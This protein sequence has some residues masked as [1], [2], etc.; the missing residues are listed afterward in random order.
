MY[1]S[2]QG[3]I[4]FRLIGWPV[5][6]GH[7]VEGI[8]SGMR[9]VEGTAFVA[10]PSGGMTLA[11][12]GADVIRFDPIGGSLDIGRW[13]LAR[14]GKRSLFWAGLNKGKRSIAVDFRNP[15]GQELLTRLICAAGEN[16]GI[17]STNFPARG[18]LSYESLKTQ[19]DDLIMVNLT[20]RRDGGSE[21]DY[22]VNA[23][24]G[25]PMLTGPSDSA[26]PVNH[27][28]PAWDFMTGQVIALAVLAAERHRRLTGEGQLVKVALKDVALAVLG[29]FGMIAEVMVTDVN[30][31]RYGNH[32]YGALGRDFETKDAKRAMVVGLTPLQWQC[33]CEA[34]GLADEFEAIGQRLGLDMSDE[35][36]R[37]RAREEIA[38]RLES[39]FRAHTLAE[40]R[41]IFEEHRV[42]WG[43]YRTVREAI[44]TDPDCS[45]ANP[46]FSMVHQPGIGSYL[47]PAS[48]L[49]FGQVGRLPAKP[50]PRLG[51]H[52][53]EILLDVLGLSEAELGV[54]HDEGIVAGPDANGPV[55][56][57]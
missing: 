47:M 18:W 40:V 39:W 48:P 35:G 6:R 34:T 45:T 1:P 51:E 13:P 36:D 5:L 28:L 14:D 11:Q 16:A 49:D 29:N 37:F 17:F 50:A 46:M 10:A 42:T 30:R 26:G 43:P 21:I 25:L 3:T 19:R 31:P 44:E 27:V 54:L 24:I 12:L 22:T 20:G 23:Q 41:D 7:P 9:V 2:Q 15:R 52:T 4:S 53:D 55:A 38:A 8:L 33:L 57:G 32:L 56:H